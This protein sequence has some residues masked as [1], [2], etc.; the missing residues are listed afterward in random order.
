MRYSRIVLLSILLMALA[1]PFLPAQSSNCVCGGFNSSRADSGWAFPDGEVFRRARTNLSDLAYFGPSGVV[2]RGITI[3]AG[4]G[5]ANDSTLASHEVFFSGWTRT[6]T[7]TPSERTALQTAVL[8]GMNL[9]LSADDA[10]HSIVDLFGVTLGGNSVE[11]NTA[12]VPDHPIFA[13]PFGRVI[14]FRGGGQYATFRGWNAGTQVL[15]TSTAGPTILLIPRLTLGPTSGAVLILSDTDIL[16]S[17]NRDIEANSSEP[18]VPVTD[19]L[20]MNILAFLC[21]PSA[22]ATAPHLVFPQ[23]ANGQGTVSSINITSAD[24]LNNVTASFILKDDNGGP[25]SPNIVGLGA[26]SAFSSTI[27][28]NRTLSLFTDGVGTLGSGTLT[29][30]GSNYL[31]GNVVFYTPGLGVTSVGSSPMAGGFDLPVVKQPIYSATP[32]VQISVEVYTG[33]AISNLSAKTASVRLELWDGNG[34]RS[35]G[36][37]Q[38]TIPARGHIAKFLFQDPFFPNFDF[39]GFTGTLRVVSRDAMISVTALQLGSSTG[40]FTAVPVTPLFR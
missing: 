8:N 14:Q 9:V 15:A 24:P 26:S 16:T 30:R 2:T 10:E 11:M 13:G 20:V 27:E 32:P 40:Q 1:A 21:N 37:R 18:S 33:M 23:I 39:R 34:R 35:D 22:P 19:A 29:V 6:S 4:T 28:P 31:G 7:F 12:A 5:S 25:Y 17:Y 36:V 3:T 38:F